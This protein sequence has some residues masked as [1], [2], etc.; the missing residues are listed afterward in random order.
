ME[1]DDVRD[2]VV[3]SGR[4]KGKGKGRGQRLQVPFVPVVFGGAPNGESEDSDPEN[5]EESRP[6]SHSCPFTSC[7]DSLLHM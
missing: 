6:P 4:G 5:V 3:V 2:V 7:P 1:T